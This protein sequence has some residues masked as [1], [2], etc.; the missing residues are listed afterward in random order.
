MAKVNYQ[1]KIKTAAEVAKIV[2]PLPRGR[3]VIMCH[4]VFD[5][6]H[7]GHDAHLFYCSTKA[8][9]VVVSVTADRHVKKG[10][11][12]PHVPEEMRAKSLAMRAI[13]DFVIID[14]NPTPL[15]NL[16]ILQPDFFAKG[17]EYFAQ[18]VKGK[19][20]EE[21]EL[22]HRYG[23]EIIS[24]P[25]DYV[26]SS[27]KILSLEKPNLRLEKLVSTL[28]WW[29]FQ[30]IQEVLEKFADKKIHVVGDTIVDKNSYCVLASAHGKTPTY[31]VRHDTTN[32]FVGGAAIVALHARAAGAD[33]TFST[34]VGDD[35][36]GEYVLNVLQEAGVKLTGLVVDRTRP[37]TQKR[38]YIADGYHLL[39]VSKVDNRPIS[40]E[41]IVSLSEGIQEIKA[42]AV[43]FSDFRHG[44]FT[45][46]SIPIL[47]GSIPDGCMSVADS[48]VA[49]RWGNITDFK[50]MDLI[51]PNER[52]ARF[53]LGD[54][55]TPL[56]PLVHELFLAS[57]ARMV[58]LKLGERGVLICENGNFYPIDSF[59]N[60]VADPV[61][62]GD[63]LLA[64]S[65]LGMLASEH[66]L[67]A[68]ILGT[69]AAAIEC[70]KE[71]NVP[72]TFQEVRDRLTALEQQAS[73]L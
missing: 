9:I 58:I 16:E 62:A 69:M 52:E 54:Q 18:G 44:I 12:R 46:R 56:R 24:T 45:K 66:P 47:K 14:D 37:T 65:T 27:T 19:T 67:S 51:T 40:E 64:Y 49:S 29:N 36:N 25:G 13:V 34:V 57:A 4:G 35:E 72:V 3:K 11:G 33:V 59:A 70:E 55:D 28:G 1:R 63:A 53:A 7:P 48:Q 17:Y 61:G 60:Q 73:H 32:T 26:Q 50:Y 10:E 39:R 8:P 38:T 20:R 2:G 31:S 15:A 41:H 71:G 30:D 43:I 5:I 21:M 22:V 68:G 6:V 42:D 23:G